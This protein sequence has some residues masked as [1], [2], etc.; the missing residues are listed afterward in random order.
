MEQKY[1]IDTN[2]L[3]DAQRGRLPKKGLD[4][5]ANAINIVFIYVKT[6]K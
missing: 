6:T 5:L 2:V 1:L 4:F 3:I